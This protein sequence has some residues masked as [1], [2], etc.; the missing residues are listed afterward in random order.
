MSIQMSIKEMAENR[1]QLLQNIENSYK[2]KTNNFYHLREKLNGQTE[3]EKKQICHEFQIT[4]QET[5]KEI[6][7]QYLK[8]KFLS[9][10]NV[11]EHKERLEKVSREIA[12]RL[13]NIPLINFGS[14]ANGVTGEV[15]DL[16][17]L[18]IIPSRD[19]K[20]VDRLF[21]MENKTSEFLV[22]A[23]EMNNKKD[24]E[25]IA[26]NGEGLSRFYTM[27]RSG[28]EVEFHVIGQKDAENMH[29]ASSPNIQRITQKTPKHE[30]RTAFD[31]E[32]REILKPEDRVDNYIKDKGK[33][34]KGFFPDMIITGDV[35][36]DN[37]DIAK[38]LQSNIYEAELKAF[39]YHNDL[40]ENGELP[41]SVDFDKFLKTMYYTDEKKYSPDK[42]KLIQIRLNL[43]LLNLKK[44]KNLRGL[45]RLNG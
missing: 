24:L 40:Y 41:E 27:G 1:Q 33:I 44:K 21:E 3:E 29:K 32:K 7:N 13:K 2:E 38:N 19:L 30:L 18:I 25:Q 20:S 45:E 14:H 6:L 26:I 5:N 11:H 16:D 35:I 22:L 37:N 9:E 17:Y 43:A 28:L 4:P 10:D 39:L 12:E 23:D 31:G 15:S 34:F 36:C 8:E 42:L